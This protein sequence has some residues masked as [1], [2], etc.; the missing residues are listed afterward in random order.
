MRKKSS[1][2]KCNQILPYSLLELTLNDE[3]KSHETQIKENNNTEK[4]NVNKVNLNNEEKTSS[5]IVRNVI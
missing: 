2:I 4:K 1:S 3:K 5:F